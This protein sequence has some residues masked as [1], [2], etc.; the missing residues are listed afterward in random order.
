VINLT[1]SALEI[2]GMRTHS[3]LRTP[4]MFWIAFSSM[5]AIVA[6]FGLLIPWATVRMMRYRVERLTL[7]GSE[8][9]DELLGAGRSVDVGAA[10]EE[11]SD[12]LGVDVAV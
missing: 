10:G 2:G 5:I 4:A 9:L 1:W 11:L 3:E 6:S 7:L 8:H 12:L